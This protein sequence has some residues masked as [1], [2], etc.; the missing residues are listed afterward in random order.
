LNLFA[1]PYA[2]CIPPAELMALVVCL[3]SRGFV[4]CNIVTWQLKGR[5]NGGRRKRPLLVKGSV[6][7]YSANRYVRK[8]RGTVESGVFYMVRPEAV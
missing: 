3:Y 8:N 1:T 2:C 4:G 5:N 6:N 7:T